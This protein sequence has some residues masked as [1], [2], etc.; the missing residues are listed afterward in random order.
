MLGAVYGDIIGSY[1]E[2]HCTKE[3]DFDLFPAGASFTDDTVLT[4]A[5][6]DAI[7]YNSRNAGDFF[8]KR[9][10]AKEY[11]YRYKQYFS[12]YPNAGFG[13]M[14]RRWAQGS[15]L[16]K[17]N[18]YANGGA[19]RVVPIAYAYDSLEEVCLQA[20]LSCLYTHHHREAVQAA[21]AVASAVY[22]ALHGGDKPAIRAYIEKTYRYD[23]QMSLTD[24]R[25]SYVFDSR[26]SYSV[27]PAILAFLES[28][29]YESAVRNAVSLGGD[30]DTMACIAGGI[31]QAYYKE[32]PDYIS[33]KCNRLLDSGLKDIFRRFC[34]KYSW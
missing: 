8:D 20:K 5:V 11:A 30:A 28:T 15:A 9:L 33:A 34:E 14:F 7:L 32:I 26:A 12:R 22:M 6:C 2:T 31:A 18:S 1:Y 29:D 13:N 24:L 27:P 17:Q 10:R 21:Q 4:A 23:L 16:Q 3:Y 25:G 19:M